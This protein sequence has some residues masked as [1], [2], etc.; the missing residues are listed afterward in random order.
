MPAFARSCR[1]RQLLRSALEPLPESAGQQLWAQSSHGREWPKAAR[2]LL[3]V[4][5][6]NRTLPL[7]RMSRCLHPLPRRWISE[8]TGHEIDKRTDFWREMSVPRVKGVKRKIVDFIVC[9]KTL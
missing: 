7:G 5:G 9:E 6:R 2:L 4:E 3:T 8:V 1:E